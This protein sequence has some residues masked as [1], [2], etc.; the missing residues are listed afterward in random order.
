VEK[1]DKILQKANELG[2]LIHHHEIVRRFRSLAERLEQDE[3]ARNLLDDLAQISQE[4]H[5]KQSAGQPIEPEDKRRLAEIEEKV[6]ANSL[7]SEFLATQSYYLHLMDQI[8]YRIS[9]PEG[10]PPRDSGIILPGEERSRIVL[11]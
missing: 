4:L 2:H 11:P 3:T 9:H 7:L 6:K 1:L 8:N 10:E 5:E